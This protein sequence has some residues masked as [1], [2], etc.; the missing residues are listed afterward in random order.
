[1][2]D[3]LTNVIKLSRTECECF[4]DDKPTD[5]NE[6]QAD[7][8]L[9]ELEGISLTILG[10]AADCEKGG[11]WELLAW[12]RE[13]ATKA[14]KADLLGCIGT[15]YT[16][17]RPAY[18]GVLG[19]NSFTSSLNLSESIVGLKMAFPQ[20]VGGTMTVK[21]IGLAVNQSVPVTV[22]VYNNDE[23]QTTP[24]ASYTINTTAN[25]LTYATL[26]TPLELPMWSNN[27]SRL[28]YYFVYT[29]TSGLQPKDNKMDCGCGGV[30]PAW[31]QWVLPVG[32]QGNN[33]SYSQFTTSNKAN[34]ILLDVDFRCNTARLICSDDKPFDFN[35]NGWDMQIAYAVR[36][37][38]GALLL[39][40]ML[41]SANL[42]RYTMMERE[43]TYGMRN[44]ALKMYNDFIAYLCDNKE[45]YSGCLKCKDNPNFHMGNI[46]A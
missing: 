7:V 24:L 41:D 13:E 23:N 32:M 3:C 33:N 40:K 26:G 27:V 30:P 31:K 2:E 28:E 12:A 45:V 17:R 37:K 11:I 42:N 4:D 8:Y 39:Q 22:D 14:F 21:R 5:Y 36:W 29:R 34:G 16:P 44:H 18:S 9:D 25:S 35:N 10:G 46:I 43:K 6:G 38:A 1:M 15:N 20:I 19:Q